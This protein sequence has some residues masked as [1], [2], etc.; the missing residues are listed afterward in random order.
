MKRSVLI[1]AAGLTVLAAAITVT[2]TVIVPTANAR[3]RDNEMRAA[4]QV[5][6]RLAEP[7]VLSGRSPTGEVEMIDCS[8]ADAAEHASIIS[9]RAEQEQEPVMRAELL[10]TL[11]ALKAGRGET[12]EAAAIQRMAA[13]TFLDTGEYERFY[14]ATRAAL[15]HLIRAGDVQAAGERAEALLGADLPPSPEM[16]AALRLIAG[17]YH[18][19]A[20]ADTAPWEPTKVENHLTA[21][22]TWLRPLAAQSL[23]RDGHPAAGSAQLELDRI[24][25]TREL[26]PDRMAV[27]EGAVSVNGEGAA[28][29]AVCLAPAPAKPEATPAFRTYTNSAGTYVLPLLPPGAYTVWVELL[30]FHLQPPAVDANGVDDRLVISSDG[31]PEVL[32]LYPSHYRLLPVS[33]AVCEP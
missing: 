30:P 28:G 12:A 4:R 15:R 7:V 31:I 33:I 8:A 21:A 19:A 5:A 23:E 22:E 18:I 9:R 16:G 1:I 10:E 13:R 25:A 17:R 3:Q 11:A 2:L 14:A 6:G 20:A 29:I 27:L 24:T 32:T 26:A